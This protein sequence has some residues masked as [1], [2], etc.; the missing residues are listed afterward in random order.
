VLQQMYIRHLLLDNRGSS[1]QLTVWLKWIKSTVS[2]SFFGGRGGS[3][4]QKLSFVS[5]LQNYF[6]W[7]RV[8]IFIKFTSYNYISQLVFHAQQV[9]LCNYKES[10]G[11]V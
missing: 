4:F 10:N 8:R 7:E 2:S 1:L 5:D 9:Y 3:G 11:M 6:D